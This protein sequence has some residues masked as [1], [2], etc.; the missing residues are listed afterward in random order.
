[1][2]HCFLSRANARL[3]CSD[4]TRLCDGIPGET[5]TE[6]RVSFLA[7]LPGFATLFIFGTLLTKGG[8]SI[9]R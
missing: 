6:T 3:N 9:L 4:G 8:C 7:R 2:F 5:L 1:M